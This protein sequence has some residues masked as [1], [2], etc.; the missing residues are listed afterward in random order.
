M[1]IMYLGTIAHYELCTTVEIIAV[2]LADIM[3]QIYDIM[4]FFF[5]FGR[6]LNRA[7]SKK[8]WY[9]TN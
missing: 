9:D 1:Y 7:N 8:Q 2:F 4:F 3:T 5:Y 6:Q